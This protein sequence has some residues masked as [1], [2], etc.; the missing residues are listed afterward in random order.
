MILE[1]LTSYPLHILGH[2]LRL[3][4]LPVSS[5]PQTWVQPS[6]ISN[7]ITLHITICGSLTGP[8]ISH[9]TGTWLVS[10]SHFVHDWIVVFEV[11]AALAAFEWW[12]SSWRQNWSYAVERKLL[13]VVRLVISNADEVTACKSTTSNQCA[14]TQAFDIA[15]LPATIFSKNCHANRHLKRMQ[16]L[17]CFVN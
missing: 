3:N 2:I 6:Q 5:P 15:C 14:R 12:P 17:P 10:M 1:L 9:R 13:H 11:Q 4:K 8:L 16:L 7:D